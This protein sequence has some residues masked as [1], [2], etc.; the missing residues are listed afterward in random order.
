MTTRTDLF[1]QP[2][3][4]AQGSLFGDGGMEVPQ[5]SVRPDVAA[6]RRRLHEALAKARAA[7]AVPWKERDRRV[8]T[9]MF[10]NMANWLPD[11]EAARL[12]AEFAREIDRLVGAV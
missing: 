4:P 5:R 7:P 12:R 6:V 2:T 3:D 1:G 9:I 11:D 10:P 8:W